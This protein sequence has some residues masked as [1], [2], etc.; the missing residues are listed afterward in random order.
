M[1]SSKIRRALS[2]KRQLPLPLK[3]HGGKRPGSGRKPGPGPR[4]S[5]HKTRP[6]VTAR[7]PVH[8]TVR[9]E[10]D[11]PGLRNFRRAQV[12]RRAF[13][14]ACVKPGFKICQ[15][16]IQGNH[17]HLVCEAIDR[18]ALASGIQGW[19]VRV[20]RGINRAVGRKGKLFFDRY[21]VTVIKTP[22]QMRNTLCYVL[23]NARRHRERIDRRFGGVD[24]FSSGWWF[25]G[26]RDNAWRAGQSPPEMRTVA[27]AETWL[28]RVGWKKARFGLIAIDEVPPAA[29]A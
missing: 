21:Y 10:R 17:I 2:S 26:W 5:S 11:V 1:L 24:P 19:A 27:E 8:V 22:S 14:K 23:Q 13:V 18:Q 20:A 9:M 4:R 16:S 3:R 12:L 7:W 28:L 25:D 29:G 6:L 15:F